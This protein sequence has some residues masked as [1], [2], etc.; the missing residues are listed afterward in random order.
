MPEKFPRGTEA[1]SQSPLFWVN[2]KD[3]YLRQLLIRDI[4]A[5]TKRDL[6]V[7]FTECDRSQAQIDQ[8][9]DIYLSEL[10][11]N[12]SSNSVDLVLETNG[13]FTDATEKICAI[14]RNAK[15]DLRVIVPRRAK[16][17]GTVIA[18]CGDAIVMG[19]DSEL[20]PIDPF[21]AGIPADYIVKAGAV[22]AQRDPILLQT[23]ESAIKQTIELATYLLHTGML[24]G[25]Q[26]AEVRDMVGKLATRQHYHSHGSVIDAEEGKRIGLNVVEHPSTSPLWQKIWL[27]RSMYSFDCQQRGYSKVFEGAQISSPVAMPAPKP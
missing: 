4:Q 5:E 13:G 20:G 25:K 12:R 14:L 10:L 22:I 18:F 9:D 24:K 15:L 19:P 21:V 27:L 6:I 26:E 23:A 2:Q 16:S 7:Y 17:N 11:S 1:P 3:R 8:T